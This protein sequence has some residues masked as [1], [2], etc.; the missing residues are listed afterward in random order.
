MPDVEDQLVWQG[1]W[2]AGESYVALDAVYSGATVYVCTANHTSAEGNAPPNDDFWELAA[3]SSVGSAYA[4]VEEYR[5]VI[6]KTDDADDT[7]IERH[8]KAVSRFIDRKTG[9]F[10]SKDASAVARV[11]VAKYSDYLDLDYEGDCPGLAS[12]SGLEIKVDTDDDSSFA[13]ETAWSTS[14]YDLLPRQADQGPEAKPWNR[15]EVRRSSSQYF[16]PGNKV[17]VTGIFGWPSVP[18]AIWSAT[19][20]L[21]ALWRRESPGSTGTMMELDQTVNMSPV[22]RGLVNRLLEAYPGRVSL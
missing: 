4:S 18:E 8:L 7:V 19:I 12:T 2:A 22:A 9:Q 6:E 21:A 20:E 15:I 5:S 1:E 13:D 11:F 17:Q 14:D 10:F 16:V 3:P